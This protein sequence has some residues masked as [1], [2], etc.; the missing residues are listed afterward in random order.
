MHKAV[1]LLLATGSRDEWPLSAGTT[2][3]D[4]ATKHRTLITVTHRHH[5]HAQVAYDFKETDGIYMLRQK[6]TASV[7]LYGALSRWNTM[8]MACSFTTKAQNDQ[9]GTA[10]QAVFS[11]M[12]FSVPQ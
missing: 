7:S 9:A 3:V 5:G 4:R 10:A 8:R 2:E 1:Q 6:D 12:A 11:V